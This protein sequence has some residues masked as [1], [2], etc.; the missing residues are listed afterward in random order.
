MKKNTRFYSMYSAFVSIIIILFGIGLV[1]TA[2]ICLAQDSPWTTKAD[3][4]IARSHHSTCVVNGKIYVIGG[5]HR[6]GEG[7]GAPTSGSV[8]E[9]DPS[10]NTWT[11]KKEMPRK[12]ESLSISAVNGKIYAIGGSGELC[13][14]QLPW[15]EEYDP[16]TD[17]WDSSKKPMRVGRRGLSTSVVNGKIYAIGG[18]QPGTDTYL[19]TVE[20][21]DPITDTWITKSPMQVGRGWFATC[22]VEGKIYAFGGQRANIANAV[23]KTTEE[24]DPVTDTWIFKDDMPA[25]VVGNAASSVNGLIYSLEGTTGPGGSRESH[26]RGL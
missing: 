15:V 22:A 3:M 2:S 8:E 24:Y 19:T 4:N 6:T 21:Y 12:R 23:T 26:V 5:S 7:C 25:A 17:T 20:E 18:Y 10:T 14:G 13:R 11:I 9:Y 1:G 16:L